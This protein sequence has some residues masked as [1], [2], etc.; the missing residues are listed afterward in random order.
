MGNERF[1]AKIERMAGQRREASRGRPRLDAHITG[2]AGERHSGV[3]L[4]EGG[5][6]YTVASGRN[7][8]AEPGT[9]GKFLRCCARCGSCLISAAN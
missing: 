4:G 7:Q 6:L 9:V 1:Y 2:Q 3:C 8:R 5:A